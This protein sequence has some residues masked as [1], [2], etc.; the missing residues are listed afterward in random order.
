MLQL[1]IS[2]PVILQAL[3]IPSVSYIIYV[4]I[5]RLYFS[6][7][8]KYPGPKLA[9]A[10]YWYE[11]YYNC[12]KGSGGQY[13]KQINHLHDRYGPVVRIAPEEVHI[14]DSS[15]YETFFLHN[16]LDKGPLY[17]VGGIPG[18]GFNTIDHDVHRKRRGAL[19][20]FFTRTHIESQVHVVQQKVLN[21]CA[22]L[23]KSADRALEDPSKA[24][25]R[26]DHSFEAVTMDAVHE[27]A[28]GKPSNM[29]NDMKRSRE[30]SDG[31]QT[32]SKVTHWL[33]MLPFVYDT[34]S[35]I[36]GLL[37]AW[38][39]AIIESRMSS[40]AIFDLPIFAQVQA[41]EDLKVYEQSK[42]VDK[43]Q[44]VQ[45]NVHLQILNSDLPSGDLTEERLVAEG[46][47]I[48]MAGFTTTARA[49]TVGTVHL[50]L[51]PGIL[52]RLRDE[53]A[54]VMPP[55]PASDWTPSDLP[56]WE[57]LEGLPYLSAVVKECI[58][59]SWGAIFR[60]QR[61]AKTPITY[62]TPSAT[63]VFPP[64]TNVSF[65]NPDVLMDP[66]HFP[67][68]GRFRP[69]RWIEGGKALERYFVAFGR[70]A[71]MCIGMWLALAEMYIVLSTVLT[72]FDLELVDT[73]AR[74]V[75]N[76]R[77]FATPYP[78][79]GFE[80]VKARVIVREDSTA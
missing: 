9:G 6:P 59:M 1:G 63:Y 12:I 51:N 11:F 37:P 50:F 68:P 38:I 10:T 74:N 80:K 62:D 73:D 27:I 33:H 70:G 61:T 69:E 18:S 4:I 19:A 16:K 44:K 39:S 72:R 28:Y 43:D 45:P 42:Q 3:L 57:E 41:Q 48:V 7:Y 71:R 79:P 35:T 49:L 58:R 77:D 31:L 21:L 40:L 78:Y 53:L 47:G 5:D 20:P 14:K 13:F 17:A 22:K 25:I 32:A 15:F 30:L 54:T 36:M 34:M 2:W 66:A 23:E 60:L 8:A 75:A 55:P 56:S 64:G 76:E 52:A 67:A 29:L 26:V 65:S 24:V 46:I